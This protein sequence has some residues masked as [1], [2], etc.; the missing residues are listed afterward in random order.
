MTTYRPAEGIFVGRPPCLCGAAFL[1][2]GY[3]SLRMRLAQD[4]AGQLA[5]PSIYRPATPDDAARE[6]EAAQASG[7]PARVFIARGDLQRLTGQR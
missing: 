4:K 3:G 1:L 7:D 5:C 6:L 2:H